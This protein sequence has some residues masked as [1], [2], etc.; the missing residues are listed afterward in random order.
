M[1]GLETATQP[2]TTLVHS[3][4]LMLYALGASNK[5]GFILILHS[6]ARQPDNCRKVCTPS[7]MRMWAK[8]ISLMN[9]S[10]ECSVSVGIVF[11]TRNIVLM[12]SCEE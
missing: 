12:M 5:S 10:F 3:V 7:S 6:L 4:S 2:I 8:P 11:V 9:S 1:R